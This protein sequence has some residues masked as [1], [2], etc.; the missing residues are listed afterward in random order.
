VCPSGETGGLEAVAVTPSNV[1]PLWCAK[2]DGRGSAMVSTTD[3]IAQPIIWIAG[4]EG[5]D[6]LHAFRGDTGALLWTSPQPMP[7]L[8]HFVTAMIA[9]HRLYIAGD[10]RVY[11]FGW[12]GG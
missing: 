5:D 2:L 3:G 4:A 12:G 9:G 7:G 11:A 1:E 6:R 8:R 10:N